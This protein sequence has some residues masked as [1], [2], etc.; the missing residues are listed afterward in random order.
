MVGNSFN[1]IV[2]LNIK[3]LND[4]DDIKDIGD[5][6]VNFYNNGIYEIDTFNRLYNYTDTLYSIKSNFTL[7]YYYF[8]EDK[9]K[10]LSLN[11]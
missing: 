10:S 1:K 11:N 3:D 7:E 8:N 2:N 5:G 6:L 4:Y 9:V